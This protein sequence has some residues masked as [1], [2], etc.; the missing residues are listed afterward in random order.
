MNLKQRIELI[1]NEINQAV[2][3]SQTSADKARIVCVTK[4]A[5]IE[6][7]ID[8]IK[9]GYYDIAENYLQEVNRKMPLLKQALSPEQFS[10]INWHFIGHLQRN[11]AEAVIDFSQL[12]QSVDSLRLA[13]RINQIAAKLNRK[14]NI[15]VQVNISAEESKFGIGFSDAEKLFF[16][17]LKLENINIQGVMGIGPLVADPEDSRPG[18]KQLKIFYDKI[19]QALSITEYPLMSVLSMGM[20]SDYIVALQEGST[21]VR[22]G[23]AIFKGE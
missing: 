8:I 5:K 15:L 19:N 14:V 4:Y 10:L 1:K 23:S 3:C 22:I 9:L 13:Q 17:I 12:I 11:K 6:D 20:S 18:F 21:M 7:V 2:I 16:E